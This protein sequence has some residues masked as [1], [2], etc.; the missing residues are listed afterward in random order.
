MSPERLQFL[1]KLKVRNC[2]PKTI[3]NYEQA[4]LRLAKHYN[5]SPLAMSSDEIEKYLLH[6]L[7]VEKLSPATVNLHIGAFKKFF[8][9]MAPH[10]TVMKPIGKV[11][12]VKKLPSVLTSDEIAR[13]VECA[14]N[15]KHR[16]MI[17]LVYSSGIRL[18]ECI[19]LRPCDIDGKQMLVHV[20][21]GKGEKERYTIISAHALQ[22]LREYYIKYRPT[23]YLFEGHGHTH[24][25]LR[26]VGKVIDK[27]AKRA[28]IIKKVTP[29]TLRHSFA[30]HLLE[31][32]VNLCTIQK[33]LGHASIR[34]TTIYTHVSNATIT[35][36][37]N[38]L[39]IA[40]TKKKKR[41][42]A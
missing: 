28:G 16:A 19:N 7:E 9:L 31:Q 4:L 6:E 20:V 18:S 11:K 10:R 23:T 36:I 39:D 42:G 13:M 15:L 34:T 40:L 41:R 24:Y 32:N 33:L 14:D 1:N 21:R 27:A 30:T 3:Y 38:P 35:N 37:V 5:K 26:S 22:T 12:D 17:E 8:E 25:G 2:S 29:H